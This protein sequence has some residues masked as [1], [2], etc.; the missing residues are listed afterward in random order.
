[1]AFSEFFEN[2]PNKPI[3]WLLKLVVFPFGRRYRLPNDALEQTMVKTMFN[4]SPLRDRISEPMYIGKDASDPSF[5]IED[6]FTRL[7]ATK[8][9]RDAIRKAIKDGDIENNDD[10][11]AL[12]KSA[13]EKKICS[14]SEADAY[15]AA[16]AARNLAIQVDDFPADQF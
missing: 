4:D 12:L 9:S 2:L 8:A 5:I 15:L 11:E 1:M 6:A 14:E 10:L 7:L 13:I 3:A 16:E